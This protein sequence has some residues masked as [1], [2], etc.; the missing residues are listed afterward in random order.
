MNKVL[1]SSIKMDYLTPKIL[2]DNLDKLFHFDFD[3]CPVN[4]TFDG[5]NIEWGECNFVNPP[6]GNNILK[7]VKK[8]W[9]ESQNN[10]TIIL[11]IP[12]RT[13]TTYF[14][15][16]I[17]KADVIMFIKR[18]L[19]FQGQKHTAPFPSMLVIFRNT[20]RKQPAIIS[21]DIEGAPI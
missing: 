5:L 7:W 3:P 20:K 12:A 19:T 11:L 14:H 21:V 4:P 13:D 1:T 15:D 10:K 9:N 6:Y 8:A 17:L 2:Y 16:Y 18:R